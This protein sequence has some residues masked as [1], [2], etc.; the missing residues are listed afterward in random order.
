LQ[1]HAEI[2]DTTRADVVLFP[3]SIEALL[4]KG[5]RAT[6]ADS[7]NRFSVMEFSRDSL[8]VEQRDSRIVLVF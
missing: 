8:A 7:P 1:L 3:A 4:K 5:C 2:I 6:M